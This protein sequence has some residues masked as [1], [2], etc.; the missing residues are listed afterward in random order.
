MTIAV[1]IDNIIRDNNSQA[2]KYFIKDYDPS[3]DEDSADLNCTSLID[4]LPFTSKE[5]KKYFKELDYPYELFGCARTISKHIHVELSDWLDEHEDVKVIYFSTNTSDLI[6]QSTYFFLSKGSRV[7]TVM[8]L[9]DPKN[10]WEFCDIAITINKDVVDSKPNN[11]QV[12]VIA[13]SDNKNL[14]EKADTI[15]NTFHDFLIDKPF[16]AKILKSAVK[17][18][19]IKNK[20]FN[21]PIKFRLPWMNQK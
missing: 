20:I 2:L 10:I 11:K 15:Y 1:E 19:S 4:E 12:I 6:I 3:F 14:Q 16:D 13:K 17:K 21:L 7:K 9:D 5:G 8:F 18:T